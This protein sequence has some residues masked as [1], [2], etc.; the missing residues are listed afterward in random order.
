V[1]DSVGKTT[2]AKSLNCLRPRRMMVLFGAS[3]GPVEPLDPLV[4]AAKGSLFLTRPSLA[5]YSATREELTWRAGEVLK[6]VSEGSLKIRIDKVY[7][8]ADAL[9]AHRDL[10]GRKTAGKFLLLPS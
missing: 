5:Q 6:W 2:F 4:L 3:S 10:E 7:R 1:Y 9:Q 8:L